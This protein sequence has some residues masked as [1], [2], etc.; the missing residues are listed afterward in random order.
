MTMVNSHTTRQASTVLARHWVKP[1]TPQA[2][3]EDSLEVEGV[4]PLAG[5]QTTVVDTGPAGRLSRRK[6]LC[7]GPRRSRCRVGIN[8]I[9][10][11][12]ERKDVH[13]CI[14]R[15]EPL[16]RGPSV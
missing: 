3:F 8:H 13:C 9:N 4:E 10:F 2:V 7:N 12:Y 16:I 15:K 6:K 14:D 11:S 1:A 5:T